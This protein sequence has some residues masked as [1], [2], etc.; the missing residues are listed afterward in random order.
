MSKCGRLWA[1]EGTC[2]CTVGHD[3]CIYGVLGRSLVRGRARLNF[4]EEAVGAFF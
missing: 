1:Y 3:V 4:D 2:E